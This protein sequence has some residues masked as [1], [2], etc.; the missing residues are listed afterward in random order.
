[1][2]Y[3][4]DV[5]ALGLDIGERNIGVA[6]SDPTGTI[7]RPLRTIARTSLKQDLETLRSL[8]DE[9]EA[10]ALVVGYPRNMDGSIGPQAAKIE[11]MIESLKT[12]GVPVF[13]SDER[14]SSREAEQRMLESGL[15]S[16]ER[17]S[18]RDEFAAAVILQRYF[19]EGSV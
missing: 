17:N 1:M 18:R 5:R 15:D 13:K 16:R 11:S 9:C 2:R 12:L 7:T 3:N 19:D 14:L 10:V 4:R 8:I 6:I